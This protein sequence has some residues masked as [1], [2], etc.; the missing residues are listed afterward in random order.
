MPA[1]PAVDT[2]SAQTKGAVLGKR[3]L[4][5]VWSDRKRTVLPSWISPIPSE[6][7]SARAGKLTADQ[8]RTLCTVHLVITLIRL[9]GHCE[10]KDRRHDL[11]TNF[12]HLVTATGALFRRSVGTE[13]IQLYQ[14][15]MQAYLKGHLRLYPHLNLSPKHHL[16][17]HLPEFLMGFGPVHGWVTW[18]FERL[19]FGFQNTNTNGKVGTK[20]LLY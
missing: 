6:A 19:V 9:W 16:S 18:G 1:P 10:P 12:M 20:I 14:E 17:L 8:W 7:G 5:E 11:L 15:S 2:S 4:P 3:I 13:T